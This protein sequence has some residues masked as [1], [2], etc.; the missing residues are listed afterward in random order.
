MSPRKFVPRPQFEDY[1]E[2][3]KDFISMERKEGVILLT[4]HHEGGPV[5]WNEAMHNALP[6]AFHDVGNDLENQVMIMTSTDPYWIGISDPEAR[7]RFDHDIYYIDATK[8]VENLIFDVDIP[9]IAAVNGPGFHT[10]LAL[11]CDITICTENAIF[12][13]GHFMVGYVAGDGQFLTFQELL[14]LKRSA[15]ALYTGQQINAQMAK[16]WGLVNEIVSKEDLVGRAREIAALIMKQPRATRC[17]THH[18]ITR[19][20]K[21]RLINDFQFHIA[22]EG[23][24][25]HCNSPDHDL[26]R[27][28]ETW[29][30]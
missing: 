5:L 9:T 29:E 6:Q 2:K 19:P 1:K 11:L 17:M 16:E 7:F 25:A 14:G 20:W 8:I 3:Y 4:M 10:E 22:Q 12:Q 15:Y 30:K 23:F 26:N 27:I 24:G 13:D 28:K 21:R 18:I